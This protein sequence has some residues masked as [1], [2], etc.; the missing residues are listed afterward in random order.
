MTNIFFNPYVRKINMLLH[1]TKA[2]LCERW[3]FWKMQRQ[4]NPWVTRV[5][6]IEL[7]KHF[8]S[9]SQAWEGRS[10]IATWHTLQSAFAS[11]F[12]MMQPRK[13]RSLCCWNHGT[14]CG[15][16]SADPTFVGPSLR[17]DKVG[18]GGSGMHGLSEGAWLGLASTFTPPSHRGS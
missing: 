9:H 14:S 2:T 7:D 16:I 8:V 5:D 10:P 12:P 3:L 13:I 15:R 18:P 17:R 4:V 11:F 6:R 1:G